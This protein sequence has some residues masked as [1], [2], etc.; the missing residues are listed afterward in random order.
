MSQ[1]EL[2]NPPNPA[3]NAAAATA[4]SPDPLANLYRMSRTA[5]LGTQEYVAINTMA[6]AAV[7]LGLASALAIVTPM[8]LII[9]LAGIICAAV[10]LWQISDSNGTQSGRGLAW[11]GIALSVIL[12]GIALSREALTK[13][14][15][16]NEERAVMRTVE[17]FG[18]VLSRGDFDAAY[19]MLGERIRERLPAEEFKANLAYRFGHRNHG[20]VLTMQSNGRVAWESDEERINRYA[21]TLAIIKLEHGMEDRQ[22]MGFHKVQDQWKIEGFGWF[23]IKPVQRARHNE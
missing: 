17:E 6:V 2:Q 7:L 11:T 8:L 19:A 13:W 10:A 16:R 9:P 14:R 3:E 20:K 21:T 18:S 23:P 12:A 22:Q 15:M 1:S 4:G 5:G